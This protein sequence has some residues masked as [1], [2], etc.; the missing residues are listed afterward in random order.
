[1]YNRLD[2]MHILSAIVEKKTKEMNSV[3]TETYDYSFTGN[4]IPYIS[5][6]TTSWNNSAAKR[7]DYQVNVVNA[8]GK[9]T[10]IVRN[11]MTSALFWGFN[12]QKLLAKI[13]NCTLAKAEEVL[14]DER[15][16]SSCMDCSQIPFD[17]FSYRHDLNNSLS[18]LYMYNADMRLVAEI[19]PNGL[20]QLY[21]YD[22]MGR[23][24]EKYYYET[25]DDEPW[26]LKHVLNRYDYY[27]KK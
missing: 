17:N 12:G 10:E 15:H 9:P 5:K 18:H 26:D 27:Y 8:Y 1:M 22:T 13:D 25:L 7:T 16:Y 6:I 21:K 23:L 11:G 14:G 2:N 4:G 19:F 24:R 3:E 20:S